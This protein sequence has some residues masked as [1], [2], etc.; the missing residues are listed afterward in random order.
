VFTVADLE[1][2]QRHLASIG[3]PLTE[4][5]DP[6]SLLLAPEHNHGLRFEISSAPRQ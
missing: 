3:I 6:K 1:Q 4:G 5:D 2:A